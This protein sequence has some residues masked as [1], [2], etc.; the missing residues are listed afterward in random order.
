MEMERVFGI[1]KTRSVLIHAGEA[2]N[3]RFTNGV[4]LY[5]TSLNAQQAHIG[6]Q[7]NVTVLKHALLHGLAQLLNTTS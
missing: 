1:M 7:K 6:D 3:I 4:S 2:G 5:A